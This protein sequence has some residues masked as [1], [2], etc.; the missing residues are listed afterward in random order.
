MEEWQC[1]AEIIAKLKRSSQRQKKKKKM[2]S[3]GQAGTKKGRGKSSSKE[4]Q[5]ENGNSS[6][7]FVEQQ[8]E[9]LRLL[10]GKRVSAVKSGC[11]NFIEV[12]AEG[13]YIRE[14]GP[15]CRIRCTCPENQ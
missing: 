7:D 9:K 10:T 5:D 4:C 13:N 11:A 1:E 3:D 6:S 15:E 12:W 2:A 14:T 8:S